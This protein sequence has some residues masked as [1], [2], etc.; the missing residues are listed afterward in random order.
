MNISGS[1]EGE[2]GKEI[3]KETPLT[4]E[5]RT[6]KLHEFIDARS[7]EVS[8][9]TSLL[10]TKLQNLNK[11]PSQLLPKHMR[12]RAMSHNRYRTPSKIRNRLKPDETVLSKPLRCRRHLRKQTQL[13][14]AYKRRSQA[15]T[16]VE[17]HVWHAKR[18]K[19]KTYFGYKVAE[20]CWAKS[21][22]AGFHFF[23]TD[24]LMYDM[25]YYEI[26]EIKSTQFEKVIDLIKEISNP[27][28]SNWVQ[29]TK[30]SSILAGTKSGTL[31]I[32]KPIQ[33]PNRFL[34]NCEYIWIPRYDDLTEYKVWFIVHPGTGLELRDWVSKQEE[35]K[36]VDVA[37]QREA[38]SLFHVAGPLTCTKLY[39]LLTKL[40]ESEEN[41]KKMEEN[42]KLI[43]IMKLIGD[44]GT[45]PRR[46]V[47]HLS[48]TPAN[49]NK[50]CS[51][52]KANVTDQYDTTNFD[53]QAKFND[54]MVEL[55]TYDYS[56][57]EKAVHLQMWNSAKPTERKF[58]ITTRSRFTHKKREFLKEQQKKKSQSKKRKSP[59]KKEEPKKEKDEPQGEIAPEE[60]EDEEVTDARKSAIA[61]IL[62]EERSRPIELTIIHDQGEPDTSKGAGFK[63]IVNGGKG[64]LIWR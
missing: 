35:N 12:R 54:A 42:N 17:T 55:A 58:V 34:E 38:F 3:T 47:S 59:N 51:V 8:T 23:K 63:I 50:I 40:A 7:E 18:M 1:G 6:V 60:E 20:R 10:R 24:C 45:Y 57:P 22:R 64:L 2:K 5:N 61:K 29:F 15:N 11:T 26:L 56:K 31:E 39:S 33:S 41:I 37:I 52:P 36:D 4:I 25:S 48:F 16:W 43:K 14:S 53:N 27:F 32:Y 13:F 30:D 46:F 21:G 49:L 44:P 9:F 19:M 28:S 62:E